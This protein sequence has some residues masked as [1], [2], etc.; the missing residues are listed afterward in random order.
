MFGARSIIYL[1]ENVSADREREI[2]KFGAEIRRVRGTYDDSVR[3]CAQE[4]AENGWFV[5]ADSSAGIDPYA[6]TLVMHG[7]GVLIEEVMQA[8]PDHQ[9]PTHI[10]IPAGVGG[11]AAAL[12]AYLWEAYGPNR[13]RVIVVE[14]IR[15][16]CVFRSI[17]AGKATNVP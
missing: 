7:Y 6:P 15:A 14:P 9:R 3:C 11:L 5:V 10:F 8:F 1:H 12:A 17:A 4:A 16:D 2:A 13:P